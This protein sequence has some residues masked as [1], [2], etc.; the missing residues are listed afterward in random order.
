MPQ[1]VACKTLKTNHKKWSRS[2]TRV[3][4]GRFRTGQ[5]RKGG[6]RGDGGGGRGWGSPYDDL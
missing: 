5:K 3:N 4:V 6:A 2:L 1:V